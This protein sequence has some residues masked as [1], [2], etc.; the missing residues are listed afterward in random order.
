MELERPST[1]IGVL[2]LQGDFDA[3]RKRLEE[4]G[5]LLN[6]E[7]LNHAFAGFKNLADYKQEV[8]DE[9]LIHIAQS[10]RRAADG[11]MAA[12]GHVYR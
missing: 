1:T 5:L 4:L 8:T 9:D 7:E 6:P 12:I 11:V 10:G 2:A 3:H